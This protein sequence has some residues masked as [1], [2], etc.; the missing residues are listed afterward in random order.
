MVFNVVIILIIRYSMLF[1]GYLVEEQRMAEQCAPVW[2]DRRVVP[3]LLYTGDR[4]IVK[5][6]K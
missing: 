2:G 6:A 3:L 5:E 1:K 4:F